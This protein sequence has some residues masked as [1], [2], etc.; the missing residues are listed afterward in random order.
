MYHPTLTPL[1]CLHQRDATY[2]R[3]LRYYVTAGESKGN[4]R[5]S[6]FKASTLR[7]YFL[8]KY[9]GPTFTVS[10]SEMGV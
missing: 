8:T 3:T 6:D 2:G 1:D 4:P 7:G 5:V 10:H 9:L